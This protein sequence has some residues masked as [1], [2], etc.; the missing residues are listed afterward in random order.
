[1]AIKKKQVGVGPVGIKIV[2]PFASAIPDRPSNFIYNQANRKLTWARDDNENAT[3]QADHFEVWR[4]V[5]DYNGTY[6]KY[7]D[8]V[9]NPD[10]GSCEY[11]DPIGNRGYWY[12]IRA[13]NSGGDESLFTHPEEAREN[14]EIVRIIGVLKNQDG[15]RITNGAVTAKLYDENS[16]EI[17]EIDGWQTLIA[18]EEIQAV[19]DP[20]SGFFE[21]IVL[22]L[23]SGDTSYVFELKSGE[24]TKTTTL[25]LDTGNEQWL[26]PASD[27][28]LKLVNRTDL[29][30]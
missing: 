17:K 27:G 26:I 8:N 28:E 20:V 30:D 11:T 22:R 7:G 23:P 1:M 16:Y 15:S 19:V 4:S 24:L 10:T 3:A 25:T 29:E 5:N 21:M 14:T 2:A 18:E 12:K 9:D 13:I 6:V